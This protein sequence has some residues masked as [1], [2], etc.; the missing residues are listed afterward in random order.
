MVCV[1]G[2]LWYLEI[3]EMIHTASLLHDDVI[4][5]ALQRRGMD[6]VNKEYGNKMAILAGEL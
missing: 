3:T 4:D 5:A 6:S 1:D 2:P